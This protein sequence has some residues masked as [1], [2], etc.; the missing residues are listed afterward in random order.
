MTVIE[1]IILFVAIVI[2]AAM[3]GIYMNWGQPDLKD[4]TVDL[5][6]DLQDTDHQ[7]QDKDLP[8]VSKKTKKHYPKKNKA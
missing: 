3:I 6:Q 8:K 1:I 2:T 4:F 5:D 7:K